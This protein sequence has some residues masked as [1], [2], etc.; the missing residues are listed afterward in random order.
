MSDFKGLVWWK[1]NGKRWVYPKSTPLRERALQI[2][3]QLERHVNAT[4]QS[5]NDELTIQSLREAHQAITQMQTMVSSGSMYE[6][7]YNMSADRMYKLQIR[8]DVM[9]DQTGCAVSRF[10]ASFRRPLNCITQQLCVSHGANAKGSTHDYV[11]MSDWKIKGIPA[12]ANTLHLFSFILS[13][14]AIMLRHWLRHYHGLGVWPNQ[15]HV[16]IRIRKS[17]AEAALGETRRALNE[18]NV[19]EAN[20]QIVTAPPSDALKLKLINSLMDSL[21]PLSWFIYADVDEHFDYQCSEPIW[22]NRCL[23]GHMVDQVAPGGVMA[24]AAPQPALAEQYPHQCRIRETLPQTKIFKVILVNV[25]GLGTMNGTH[26][27]MYNYNAEKRRFRNTHATTE[28]NKCVLRGIVRHYSMTAQQL[29]GMEEKAVT[30]EKQAIGSHQ[31]VTNYA[32]G[33]CGSYSPDGKKC[34]DY[35]LLRQHMLNATNIVKDHHLCPRV[36]RL[37]ED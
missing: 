29:A 19:P 31:V 3:Q 21:P 11:S 32:K 34:L 2:H 37:R 10:D 26:H 24:A 36:L 1:M 14:D 8:L 20:V 17:A 18:A 35:V 27:R 15:T 16:A 9:L 25:G 12:I 22:H 5:P 6:A 33:A 30:A 7:P 28:S 13:D 4:A 23:N